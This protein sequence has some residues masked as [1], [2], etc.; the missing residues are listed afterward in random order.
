MLQT[1]ILSQETLEGP[2]RGPLDVDG[3]IPAEC[4]GH[5]INAWED[6]KKCYQG[7]VGNLPAV[8]LQFSIWDA[9]ELSGVELGDED[10]GYYTLDISLE[11]P[12]PVRSSR[13]SRSSWHSSTSSYDG[14]Y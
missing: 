2:R 5:H 8:T 10:Y 13:S 3:A 6:G 12:L 7:P 4:D 9:G 11:F 14:G 1:L